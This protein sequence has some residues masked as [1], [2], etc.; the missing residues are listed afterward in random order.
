MQSISK[1]FFAT[2]A[3]FALAGMVWGIQMAASNDHT[4]SPAHGH[5]NLIGFV[6][7]AVFGA[8]YALTPGAAQTAMAQV[9]YVLTAAAVV[10]LVPGIV[11]AITD[12]GESV[13]QIG[14]VLAVLSMALFGFMVL[15]HGV[16]AAQP[17]LSGRQATHP[18]E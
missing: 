10:V 16:G 18:A 2:A 8:Y 7:M 13:A 11:F 17:T 4:L 15:R 14:S 9:H 12:R 1:L 3:L 5:L 6:A